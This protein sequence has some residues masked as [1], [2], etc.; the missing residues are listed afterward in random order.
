MAWI[1][2]DFWFNSQ[3]WLK[4]GWLITAGLAAL[5]VGA[6]EPLQTAKVVGNQRQT[7][8]GAIGDRI[9]ILP[10][11]HARTMT[12]LESNFPH[13]TVGYGAQ[14]KQAYLAESMIDARDF[15]DM[16]QDRKLLRTAGMQIVVKSPAETAAKLVELA[17][18]L[19]GYVQSSQVNG[20]QFA[21]NATVTIR[22][23]VSKLD[24]ARTAIRKLSLRVDSDHLD[25]ED[26]T[27]NYVDLEARLR[28]LRAQERQY[29]EILKR[30]STVKDTLQ[31][32]EKLNEVRGQ[33]EQQQAEFATLSKQVETV[34]I[35]VSLNGEADAQV[36]G[37]PWRP[38]LRLK[39]AARDGLD[40]LGEYLATM[41]SI[42]FYL[43]SILLWLGTILIGAAAAWR[44]LGWAARILFAFPKRILVDKGAN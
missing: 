1:R 23:P 16:Q 41:T 25:A 3:K 39:I 6:I 15:Q 36:F 44:V 34:A 22:V 11:R 31:V 14:A 40:G 2:R 43:P 7:G 24:E 4:T 27:R 10:L 29:L 17:E 35:S 33:I 42:A 8:L 37:L 30:A 20:N 13:E 26:V 5:Y 19:G 38:L 28:N 18:D 12:K 32:S 9:S 21:A